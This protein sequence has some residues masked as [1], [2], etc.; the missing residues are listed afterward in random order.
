MLTAP[1]LAQLL[2][3]LG[4]TQP[5]VAARLHFCHVLPPQVL[6]TGL[7][8]GY[9]AV[10][11]VFEGEQT[12]AALCKEGE[13]AFCDAAVIKVAAVYTICTVACKSPVRGVRAVPGPCPP[14]HAQVAFCA[15]QQPGVAASISTVA[16][17]R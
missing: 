9:A 10:T 17:C 16:C 12:F 6:S 4:S 2:T 5:A 15:S 11:L 1:A 8:L 7:I 13:P 3:A 14:R